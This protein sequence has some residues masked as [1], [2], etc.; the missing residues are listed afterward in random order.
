M[1]YAQFHGITLAEDGR[2]NSL[3]VESVD[4]DPLVTHPGRLWYNRQDKRVKFTTIGETGALIVLSFTSLQEMAQ[5]LALKLDKSEYTPENI[6][7]MIKLVDGQG[8]GLD[9]DTLDGLHATAFATATQGGKADTAVQPGDLSVVATTGQYSDLLGKPALGTAAPKNVPATGNAASGEVVLGSD[10][11]L[12][13]TRDPKA[14]THAIAD[15]TGLQT[16]LNGK[17]PNIATGTTANYWRGDKSWRDFF[18]DVRAATLT[19]LSTATNAVITA[20]DTVL[21]ALG[22]LQKQVTDNLTALTNHTGNTSNP[23][24][25]TAAQVGADSVGT[26]T[27]VMNTHTG[28]ADPHSQYLLKTATPASHNHDAGNITSGTLA[29]ARLSGTYTN[30]NI[31][32]NAATA[33][34]IQNARTLTV[35][36]AGKSFDGSGNVSWSL[37]EIGATPQVLHLSGGF[38]FNSLAGT[39]PA[40]YRVVWNTGNANL[41]NSPSGN[42][43]GMMFASQGSHARWNIQMFLAQGANPGMYLRGSSDGGGV[44][45]WGA[46]EKVWHSG[47]DGSGSGL[48]A[49]LLDGFHADANATAY[50][51]ALRNGN[52]D[53]SMRYGYTDYVSMAHGSSARTTDTVFY[54]STDQFI[55]KN[56]L[57]GFKASLGLNNVPNVDT[58]NANNLNAGTIPDARLP[59]R[60]GAVAQTIADWNAATSNGWYMASNATNAPAASEWFIGYTENHGA[61]GWCTQTVHGF[62]T[63]SSSDTKTYRREQNN[64]AWGAWYRLRLS[65]AEQSAIYLNASNINAG[66]LPEARLP[67]ATLTVNDTIDCGEL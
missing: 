34:K 16:A 54:S 31:A 66:T 21:G 40:T 44:T 37:A 17:E 50:T 64:G 18:T 65:Q 28:A 53:L 13:D 35:G 48:D 8:S 15:V 32:G 46:W 3:H 59:A 4:T 62:S 60:L 26:A 49:D 42:T 22:K 29:D 2:I 41:V 30:V 67:A 38:D 36:A 6:L 10:T 57:E 51:I 7:A 56:T 1:A 25:T 52:A 5:A 45:T 19:G 12:T 47:N 27:Q 14:H 55:R 58:R 20:T 24:G 33:T 61:V 11:R 9:A 63:D 39:D 43:A 23:H